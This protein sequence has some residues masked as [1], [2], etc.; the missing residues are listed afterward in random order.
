MRGMRRHCCD[1]MRTH[2]QVLREPNES[3][4]VVADRPILYDPVF[5]EYRLVSTGLLTDRQVISWCPW[6][7]A[8]LPQSQRERWFTELAR[9]GL[10]VDDTLPDQFRT[11]AWWRV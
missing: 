10:S 5:D 2:H 11:D 7:G 3:N 9:L 1:G 4:A 6:C 8:A